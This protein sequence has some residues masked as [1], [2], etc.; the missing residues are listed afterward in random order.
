MSGG[1]S[2]IGIIKGIG[3]RDRGYSDREWT[4]D[5]WRGGREILRSGGTITDKAV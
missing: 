1:I 4:D 3:T 5:K 2:G